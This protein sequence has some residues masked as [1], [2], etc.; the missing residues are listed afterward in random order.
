VGH[1]LVIESALRQAK[2]NNL[3]SCV[4]TFANHPQ[5]VLTQTATHLLSDLQ[6]RLACFEKL[7]VQSALVLQF[8]DEL[9][10]WSAQEFVENVIKN[11]LNAEFV[12]VGYDHR[13]G[14]NR[15]GDGQVLKALGDRYGFG[16]EIIEPVK[17]GNQIVS[18]TQIRK[19]LTYGEPELA[20]VLLG[21]SYQLK[22]KVV[23]GDHRGKSIGFPTANLA[24]PVERLTPAKGVYAGYA[25]LDEAQESPLAAVCN[26][27][28]HPSFEQSELSKIEVH[29]MGY[30][31]DL[32]GNM[33][34]F[35]FIKF[36]RP[37]QKFPTVDALVS[38]IK[39]DC[40]QAQ[41]LL[42]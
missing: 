42:V 10:Q 18:S 28:V 27:G 12:S 29:I 6:D 7:G 3:Q 5:S 13:F 40:H 34:A 26:V 17:V 39:L 25:Y 22:G 35:D 38:Q 1:Q 41:K 36:L 16:V 14:K 24:V 23:S 15:Q 4:L 9:K 31:G 19:L 33:L 21:R 30:E 20:S 32:Y 37:E 2:L 8:N 11:T